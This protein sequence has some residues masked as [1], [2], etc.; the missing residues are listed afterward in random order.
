MEAEIT[1]ETLWNNNT[2]VKVVPHHS[3]SDASP[4][5]DLTLG[6]KETEDRLGLG[7]TWNFP[8]GENNSVVIPTQA[9]TWLMSKL[10]PNSTR[11][12]LSSKYGVVLALVVAYVVV[13]HAIQF[14]MRRRPAFELKG[15]LA[16]WNFFM[17]LFSAATLVRLW[18]D[19]VHL[20]SQENGLYRSICIGDD[21]T[22]TGGLWLQLAV[23]SKLFE[24]IDTLFIV[25]RKRPLIFLHWYHHAATG[26]LVYMQLVRGEAIIRWGFILNMFIHA[27]MY[28][29]FGLAAIDYKL[30]RWF[31]RNLTKMQLVQF[32][33]CFGVTAYAELIKRSG[34]Y[35][36]MSDSTF[37]MNMFVS[38]SYLYLFSKFYINAYNLRTKPKSK[39]E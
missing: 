7:W 32:A 25:L 13:I 31:A 26:Y 19:F 16:G 12:Y 5:L 35:C 17:A 27:V 20:L 4:L 36:E 33:I 18:P 39:S 3:D 37:Y 23:Y 38:I 11:A 2:F 14:W 28:A 6:Q 34:G 24:A 29:Y 15:P 22:A 8:H 1:M 30:P 21:L 10:E 9:E